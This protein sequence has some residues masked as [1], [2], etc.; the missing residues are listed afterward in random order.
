MGE[1]Y[2]IFFWQSRLENVNCI[3]LF[4]DSVHRWFFWTLRVLYKREFLRQPTVQILRNYMH[5][6]VF[7]WRMCTV[8]CL[9]QWSLFPWCVK[10]WIVDQS[11]ST[12]CGAASWFIRTTNVLM[13]VIFVPSVPLQQLIYYYSVCLRAPTVGGFAPHIRKNTCLE[14]KRNGTCS[15]F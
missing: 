5:H 13:L 6:G 12:S 1:W 4:Q 2:R 10:L 15:N 3:Y 8:V 7:P 11:S 9:I 14:A